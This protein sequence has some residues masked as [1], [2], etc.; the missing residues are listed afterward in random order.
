M[1]LI[2]LNDTYTRSAS[3]G[4]GIGPSQRLL[5]DNTQHAQETDIHAICGIRTRN[6]RKRAAK[7]LRLRQRGDRD[8]PIVRRL[9]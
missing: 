5:L 3:P 6:P 1:H 2:T 4:Q 8:R 7:D 9:K